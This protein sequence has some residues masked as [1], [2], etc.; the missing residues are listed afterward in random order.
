MPSRKISS[1]LSLRVKQLKV[2]PMMPRHLIH[3]KHQPL[4]RLLHLRSQRENL[5]IAVASLDQEEIGP[6]ISKR[7][8]A[9]RWKLMNSSLKMKPTPT[10]R[11]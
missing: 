4:L 11:T 9:L 8:W 3:Q 7:T 1:S 10:L 2:H 6:P 5:R